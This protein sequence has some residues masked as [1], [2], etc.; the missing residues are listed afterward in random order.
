MRDFWRRF[1]YDEQ[2]HRE[3]YSAWREYPYAMRNTVA[4]FLMLGFV[5]GALLAAL[6]LK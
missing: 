2:L 3:L 5:G 6:A 1:V 4:L